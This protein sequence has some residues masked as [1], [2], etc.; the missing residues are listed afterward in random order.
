MTKVNA[1]SKASQPHGIAGSRLLRTGCR[2]ENNKVRTGF[3]IDADLLPGRLASP[4]LLHAFR[5]GITVRAIL[6]C[7]NEQ[8]VVTC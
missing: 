8:D 7:M 6:E 5:S 3:P 2:N 4:V 1:S